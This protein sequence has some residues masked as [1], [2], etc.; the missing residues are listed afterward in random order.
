VLLHWRNKQ[1]ARYYTVSLQQDLF[2]GWALSLFWGSDEG[3]NGRVVHQPVASEKEG[4]L[5]I[6][7]ISARRE[8][9]GYE[10]VDV[11]FQSRR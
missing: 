2:G 8:A 11:S 10:L 7:D 4:L 3:K 9:H 5:A 1:N 6:R